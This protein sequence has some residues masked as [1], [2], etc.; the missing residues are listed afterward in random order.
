MVEGV[1][2]LNLSLSSTVSVFLQSFLAS[3]R[4]TSLASFCFFSLP[5]TV[6]TPR[7]LPSLGNEWKRFSVCEVLPDAKFWVQRAQ[8]AILSFSL[9]DLLHLSTDKIRG[10]TFEPCTAARLTWLIEKQKAEN[11]PL[12]Q[13]PHDPSPYIHIVCRDNTKGKCSRTSCKYLHICP[14]I[15]QQQQQKQ[16]PSQRRSRRRQT[17]E[18]K[19]NKEDSNQNGNNG[20]DS[21]SSSNNNNNNNQ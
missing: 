20:I 7:P 17:K 6:S 15:W 1:K 19:E 5:T 2:S 10:L 12:L 13:T 11:P 9:G 3:Q 16:Q 18:N 4:L 14:D 8:S 21:S